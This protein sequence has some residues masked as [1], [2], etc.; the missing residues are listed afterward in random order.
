MQAS[1]RTPGVLSAR[2]FV[3]LTTTIAGLGAAALFVAPDMVAKTHPFS[4]FLR[5]RRI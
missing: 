3:L 4:E 5:K 1:S 2:R